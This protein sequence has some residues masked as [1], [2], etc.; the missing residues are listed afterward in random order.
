MFDNIRRLYRHIYGAKW[1]GVGPGYHKDVWHCKWSFFFLWK[2][3]STFGFPPLHLLNGFNCFIL[4]GTS[5][6]LSPSDV[7][8]DRVASFHLLFALVIE[9]LAISMPMKPW[10]YLDDAASSLQGLMQVVEDLSGLGY[11]GWMGQKSVAF[12]MPFLR[13]I[14]NLI[15]YRYRLCLNTWGFM[16]PT[17]T[18][19]RVI[20][21]LYWP[22]W[23]W[24]P[25][26][27][28][29]LHLIGCINII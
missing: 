2:P 21:P 29:P 9:M 6:I 27:G 10:F 1:A 25:V 28:L 14:Y 24:S 26:H 18:S 5:L 19:Q 12:T 15:N 7:V 8:P 4:I 13:S 22:I 20:F 3:L 17:T 16:F 23:K 11:S